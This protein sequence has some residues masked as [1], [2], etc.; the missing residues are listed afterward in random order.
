MHSIHM[1]AASSTGRRDQNQDA[2]CVAPD[3]DL[4]VVCDGMG[5]YAGGEV[6]SQTAVEVIRHFFRAN[7]ADG[8]ITWPYPMERKLSLAENMVSVA[9]RLAH[10]AICA[11]RRGKL[12]QM[13]TTV[14]LAACAEDDIVLG[15]VGDSR[16]YR[17][18]DGQ[19]EQLTRDHSMYNELFDAGSRDLPPPEEFPY[20]NVV[21]RALGFS[22]NGE[23]RPD[24]RR[25]K[26]HAG[27]VYL[28]CTDGLHDVL[29]NERIERV[30]RNVSPQA[31]CQRLVDMAYEAGS[32]DNITVAVLRVEQ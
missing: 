23:E 4:C 26:L 9:V 13:G 6:A 25:E 30:L 32:T 10:Q 8:G 29:G 16:I 2:F 12:R 14:V 1:A 27:D 3:L 15:H 22:K 31:V 20:K 11:R 18:R 28:L 19:L 5:G 21:S 24:L 17:L 7:L